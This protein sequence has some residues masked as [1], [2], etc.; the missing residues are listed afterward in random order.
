MSKRTL[1]VLAVLATTVIWG[2]T[3]I[4]V[5]MV[6]AEI[7]PF[8]LALLRFALASLILL[9]TIYLNSAWRIS[10]HRLE[11]GRL[12]AMA[13]AGVSL[14]FVTENL[15]MVYTT[16]SSGSLVTAG[17][18]AVCAIFAVVFLKERLGWVRSLGIAISMVGVATIVMAGGEGSAESPN[19]LLGNLLICVSCLCWGFY[20]IWGKDMNSRYPDMTVTAWT[21][22]L[23]TVFL[24]PFAGYEWLVQGLGA[25]SPQ[26]WSIVAFL[27]VAASA[28]CYVFWN[29]A[30]THLD[31]SVTATFLNLVPVVALLLAGTVLGEEILP[32]QIFGG[33]LVMGG[34]YLA[35]RMPAPAELSAEGLGTL[36]D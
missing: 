23:G 30:L 18:P 36:A 22:A 32:I 19:P 1:A 20:T 27:G 15:G 17:A 8:T 25:I 21:I 4:L 29:Y 2:S 16:A 3:F 7:P 13:F 33:A 10:L 12:A 5:K 11:W 35:S 26:G 9:P 31:A 6:L 28:G 34:V 24:F 14:Y